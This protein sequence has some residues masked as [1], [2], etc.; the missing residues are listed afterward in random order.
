MAVRMDK[1]TLADARD[2]MQRGKPWTFRMEFQ[3]PNP[4]NRSGW[5]T[6][7]WLATGR[8]RNEPVEIHYGTINSGT[9][10]V[11]V[12]DWDYV[13]AKAPEKEAKGYTYVATPFIRVRQSTINTFAAAQNRPQPS[14]APTSTPAAP[15]P[16]PAPVSSAP[17]VPSLPGPWGRISTIHKLDDGTWWGLDTSGRKVVQLTKDGARNLV[18]DHQHISIAGL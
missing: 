4:N 7:F 8:G 3:G 18:R 12:K 1:L 10:M 17:A 13:E 11:L 5:S 15:Q 2:R 16:T 6:K 14:Q 9:P